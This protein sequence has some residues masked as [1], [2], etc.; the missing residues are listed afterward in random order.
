MTKARALG[1]GPLRLSGNG[2]PKDHSLPGPGPSRV[3]LPMQELVEGGGGQVSGRHSV[4]TDRCRF[5]QGDAIN[6]G[7][8]AAD[9]L[10]TGT[11]SAA[12][13]FDTD[14]AGVDASC[15]CGSCLGY[16]WEKTD[17]R[18]REDDKARS[19]SE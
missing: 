11:A 9:S 19:G 5:A 14:G 12:S 1:I 17:Q 10:V 18:Q 3:C 8:A 16:C 2:Y 13:G 7:S 6:A 15:P 4:D